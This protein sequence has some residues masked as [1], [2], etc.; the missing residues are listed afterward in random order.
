MH[1]K[2]GLRAGFFCLQDYR[3][4]SVIAAVI[5][6]RENLDMIVKIWLSTLLCALFVNSVGAQELVLESYGIRAQVTDSWR[7]Y[8]SRDHKGQYVQS[9][10]MP[11]IW[12][13]SENADISNA[14]AVTAYRRAD[15][16]SIAALIK[17]DNKRLEDILVSREEIETAGD[18]K[19]VRHVSE[20]NGLN[21]H[22]QSH[23]RFKNNVGYIFTFT[24]TKG[25]FEKNLPKFEEFLTTVELSKPKS[26][27]ALN[28][29]MTELQKANEFY[30]FGVNHLDNASRAVEKHLAEKTDDIDG[31]TLL[32]KI[33]QRKGDFQG[34]LQS[35]GKIP[36]ID[37]KTIRP[38][39][40][41]QKAQCYYA[42]GKYELARKH[43]QPVSGFFSSHPALEQ[44]YDDLMAVIT[45]NLAKPKAND[46]KNGG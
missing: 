44:R 28:E 40:Y 1:A 18:D 23:Y 17:F 29:T 39:I 10:G 8:R 6:L 22:S 37:K 31:L 46:S 15:I 20:I 2:S 41:F 26:G 14:V 33:Q 25:T 19:I 42:T 9:F 35:L 38:N 21:Y 13:E 16:D 34:A 27:P 12:S 43:L 4:D 30:R 45:K 24:A 11:K 3:P 5:R 36:L 7:S 32:A